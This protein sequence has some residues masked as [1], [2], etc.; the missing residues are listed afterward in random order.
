MNLQNLQIQKR[1][2]RQ[3]NDPKSS[4]RKHRFKV[5]SSN[6][7]MSNGSEPLEVCNGRNSHFNLSQKNPK[8]Q[9]KNKNFFEMKEEKLTVYE[10]LNRKKL[11]LLTYK[12]SHQS[13]TL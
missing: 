11:L 7:D 9:S 6:D 10:H 8:I 1:E 4:Q 2:R 12:F 5:K 13:R 3:Q